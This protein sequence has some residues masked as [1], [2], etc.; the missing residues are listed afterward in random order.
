MNQLILDQNIFR[1]VEQKYLLT[2]NQYENLMECIKDS[3]E[4]DIY[5]ESTISNIYFDTDNN[6]LIIN[7]IEK[8][9][10]KNKIRLRSYSTPNLNSKV[11]LEIKIKYKGVVAKRRIDLTLEEFYEYMNSGNMPNSNKQIMNEIDYYF[12]KYN[13]KPK[14]FLA[15]D[16]LSYYD[17]NHKEFRIT[18]DKNVRSR[19]YDLKLEYGDYGKKY[20]DED[21]Y[22]MELKTLGSIPLWFTQILSKLKIYPQS[23]SK[24]GKIYSKKI[25]EEFYV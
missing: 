25:E 7:S 3:I 10:Y 9:L 23:F 11:F 12:K 8:P 1:R 14:M 6:D 5:Y 22:I 24:Y 2:K 4:K 15:Y 19:E 21:I 17:K 13:L 20:F 18:F 16:R